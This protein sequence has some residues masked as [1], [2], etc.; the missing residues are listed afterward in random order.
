MSKVCITSWSLLFDT[1]LSS[2]PIKIVSQC[3][4]LL[5]LA[6]PNQGGQLRDLVGVHARLILRKN[7]QLRRLACDW[8]LFS[9]S[10]IRDW[11]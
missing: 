6:P 4:A 9:G 7:E 5:Y 8:Q 2:Y 11:S 3:Q 10:E 1:K